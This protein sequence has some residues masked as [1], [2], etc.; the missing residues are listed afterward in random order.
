MK[1]VLHIRHCFTG[2]VLFDTE[3]GVVEPKH[4]GV[5]CKHTGMLITKAPETRPL[6]EA[7]ELYGQSQHE[8]AHI[9]QFYLDHTNSEQIRGFCVPFFGGLPRAEAAIYTLTDQTEAVRCDEELQ[10][11]RTFC[12][13]LYRVWQYKRNIHDCSIN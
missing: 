12:Q 13:R 5:S 11:Y 3:D 1:E 4:F 9:D 8:P 7:I 2:I 10:R 6:I